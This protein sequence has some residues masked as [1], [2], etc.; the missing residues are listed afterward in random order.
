MG[1]LVCYDRGNHLF[2]QRRGLLA[3][4]QAGLSERDE[5][6]VLHSSGQEVRDGYQV[7]R[8]WEGQAGLKT[9]QSGEDLITSVS[10]CTHLISWGGS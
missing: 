5:S 6:P 4:Q 8:Q 9:E 7:W 1:E 10:V 3:H 2:L